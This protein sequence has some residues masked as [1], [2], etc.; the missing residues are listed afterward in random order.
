MMK[1]A[2]LN[3][4]NIA[5]ILNI[6]NISNNTTFRKTSLDNKLKANPSNLK[7]KSTSKISLGN[8]NNN[9]NNITK[10][11][12]LSQNKPFKKNISNIQTLKYMP[13]RL[14]KISGHSEIKLRDIGG[15][16]FKYES[17]FPSTS[18]NN[19]VKT[20]TKK[21]MEQE[22]NSSNNDTEFRTAYVLKNA[23]ISE[24]FNK[25]ENNK[26]LFTENGKG[27][28]EELFSQLSKLIDSQVKT[29]FDFDE[30]YN[31]TNNNNVCVKNHFDKNKNLFNNTTSDNLSSM[32]NTYFSNTFMSNSANNTNTNNYCYFDTNTNFNTNISSRTNY[33]NNSFNVNNN[34]SPKTKKYIITW[35]NFN[36]L[37][38][39]LMTFIFT[40]FRECK[41]ENIKIKKKIKENEIKCEKMEKKFRENQKLL[42]KLEANSRI[43]KQ[44][45]TEEQI[46]KQ[47]NNF[48]IKENKYII[49]IYKLQT[50]IINLTSLLDK[51]KDYFDKYLESKAEMKDQNQRLIGL[52]NEF[53]KEL[54]N[55]NTNIALQNDSIDDLNNKIQNYEDEISMFKQGVEENKKIDIE[56]TTRIKKLEMMLMEREENIVMI[57]EELEWFTREYD[58]EKYLHSN[59]QNE[60]KIL[61]NRLYS[62]SNDEKKIDN[63]A[64][65]NANSTSN[66]A[67]NG[68]DKEDK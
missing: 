12:I 26:D 50:E 68:I 11:F 38:N 65:N 37:I 55:A 34:I 9:S 8:S 15:S 58:R 60:L 3:D 19:N 17:I 5:N 62:N 53:L 39:K 16:R 40:E 6:N 35:Y 43:N 57:N 25:L 41:T 33:N 29:C 28:F 30:I 14:I 4:N 21:L 2:S 46:K 51:A 13:K 23:K 44:R 20:E 1:L 22:M 42:Y 52:K 36:L 31:N 56:R 47:E 24:N 48:K 66:P 49:E 67:N 32:Q 64:N 45:L 61:E 63:N 27:K 59:T 10:S 54:K 7:S 18:K